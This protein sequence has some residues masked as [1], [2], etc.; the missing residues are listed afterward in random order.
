MSTLAQLR[1]R[2]ERARQTISEAV[3]IELLSGNLRA[4]ATTSSG[5]W[6]NKRLRRGVA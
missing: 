1:A 2:A 6:R 5:A 3:R 4:G